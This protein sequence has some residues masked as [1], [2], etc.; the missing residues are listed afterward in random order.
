MVASERVS[1]SSRKDMF[2]IT[3]E[4]PILSWTIGTNL[5]DL[6]DIVVELSFPIEK[7]VE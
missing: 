4:L 3:L 5:L 2:S 1:P 6:S 7:S